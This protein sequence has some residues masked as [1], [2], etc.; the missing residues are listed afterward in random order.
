M[1]PLPSMD[2]ET[3]LPQSINQLAISYA[4]STLDNHAA[5]LVD[6]YRKMPIEGVYKDLG[7]VAEYVELMEKLGG[8]SAGES[9][10]AQG[11]T[12]E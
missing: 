9:S 12:V 11:W 3:G 2:P 8:L 4:E 5:H 10:E 7:S 6:S 1:S